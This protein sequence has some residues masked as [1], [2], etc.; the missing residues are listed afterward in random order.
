MPPTALSPADRSRRH[1]EALPQP[2][3]GV[4]HIG[5]APLQSAH[6]GRIAGRNCTIVAQL[7]AAAFGVPYR[8]IAAAG[9]GARH[10]ALAR[11]SAMYVAHVVLGMSYTDIG[12]AFERDRTTAAHACRHVEDRRDDA[13]F[14]AFLNSIE[15]A[16]R[17]LRRRFV[18]RV[19]P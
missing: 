2:C 9:R 18:L 14:D 8:D 11:Q 15:G 6:C 19:Q 1:S 16:C 4:R 17:I 10:V 7:T 13:A 5:H 3:L 12:R